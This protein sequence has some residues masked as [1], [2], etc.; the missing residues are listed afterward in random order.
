MYVN[1]FL[2][3]SSKSTIW[4]KS[5]NLSKR[6]AWSISNFRKFKTFSNL[7]TIKSLHKILVSLT[8]NSAFWN[9]AYY[10]NI[11]IPARTTYLRHS[12]VPNPFNFREETQQR[13]VGHDVPKSAKNK[14]VSV[15]RFHIIKSMGRLILDHH[16]T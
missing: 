16:V 11:I 1:F 6:V 14:F 3:I 8:E 10:L 9:I 4:S 13:R 12:K 2:R 15:I 5:R 7:G